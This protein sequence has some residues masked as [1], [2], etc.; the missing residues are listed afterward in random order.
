MYGG[1]LGSLL[2][3]APMGFGPTPL[4][5]ALRELVLP[6]AVSFEVL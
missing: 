1:N 4:M 2:A 6:R 5:D 3:A